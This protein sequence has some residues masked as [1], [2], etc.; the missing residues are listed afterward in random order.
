[1]PCGRQDFAPMG[2]RLPEFDGINAHRVGG[3][4]NLQV[5]PRSGIQRSPVVKPGGDTPGHPFQDGGVV[6]EPDGAGS[7]RA[8]RNAGRTRPGPLLPRRY[9]TI[10]VANGSPVSS[11]R[12]RVRRRPAPALAHHY[13]VQRGKAVAGDRGHFPT[14]ISYCGS[15]PVQISRCSVVGCEIVVDPAGAQPDRPTAL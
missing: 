4:L 15:A 14:H 3:L 11:Q 10:R 5:V 6:G 8:R 13:P 2:A 1:M 9:R 12:H 7:R